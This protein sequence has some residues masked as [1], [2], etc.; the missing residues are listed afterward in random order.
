MPS[1][2][3][4][5]LAFGMY[6][7]RT[8]NGSQDD[9]RAVHPHRHLR[10]FLRRQ[11]NLAV[12]PGRPAPSVALGDLPHAD[13]RVRPGPQHH[14]LQRPDR[15]PV[16]LPRR[17]EDPP[18]QPGYVAPRGSASRWRPSR[19]RPPVR[20]PSLVSNLPLGSPGSRPRCSKAH[21]P[22]SAPFRARP[23]RPA[24]GRF[25]AADRLEERRHHGRESRCLSAAGI[26]FLGILSRRG[27]PPLSRSAYQA[28]GPG[29]RRGFHVPR[30]RDTTG[31][32]APYTPRPAVFTR[33][34]ESPP[35]AA[36]RLYQRPG[37]ITR[38]FVPSFRALRL[39]GIIR[40]SLAF[41]RPVFPSPGCSPGRNGG[42]WASSPSFA[43]PAGRTRR[44]HVEAGTDLEH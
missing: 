7:R 8:G 2:R 5:P 25:P 38:V 40:G 30:T 18:P 41:A 36:C 21:L 35:V 13:Q 28:R 23:I 24:S 39:R 29:P 6:T 9:A 1:G 42:P 34:A 4:F 14:L 43:P 26:R 12:D 3:C 20:S 15:G 22:T 16:L 37:P 19:A 31:V 33:P 10:P 32:G 11:G 44:A 27:L 17:L